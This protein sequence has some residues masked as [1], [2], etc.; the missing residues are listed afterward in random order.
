MHYQKKKLLY[1]KNIDLSCYINVDKYCMCTIHCLRKFLNL[2]RKR[3]I[4]P[5]KLSNKHAIKSLNF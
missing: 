2:V 3:K 1:V 4:V 5:S